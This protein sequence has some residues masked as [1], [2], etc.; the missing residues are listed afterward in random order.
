[1]NRA[2]IQDSLDTLKIL[3]DTREQPTGLF[4]KRMEQIDLPWERRKLDF[5]D[6]S[7]CVL[8]ADGVEIDFSPS[9]ALERKMHTDELAQC[10]T[11]S[12][13]RFA[14]EFGRAKDADAKL[15]LLVENASWEQVFN[16]KYRTRVSPKA[17]SASML[18]WLAR[19]NCQIIMCK[20]ETTP[21][22]IREICYREAKERLEVMA[23]VKPRT[24]CT[25]K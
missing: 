2:E 12:R 7:A 24:S 6:Y 25:G 10:L 22:L 21:K 19:Y 9:F 23:G 11:R 3:V 4:E 13:D 5:G 8:D 20:A 15:Y 14:R 18:A 17:L 1:M 16:G